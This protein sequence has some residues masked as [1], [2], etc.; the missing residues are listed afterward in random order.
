ML[1]QSL[2]FSECF[3][4]VLVFKISFKKFHTL[5]PQNTTPPLKELELKE[6]YIYSSNV[7]LLQKF[8]AD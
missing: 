1:R 6:K 2:K 8:C 4:K 7:W 5:R 3:L